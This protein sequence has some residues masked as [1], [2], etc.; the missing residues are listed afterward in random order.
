ML[1]VY[2]CHLRPGGGIFEEFETERFGFYLDLFIDVYFKET[3]FEMKLS[4][5]IYFFQQTQASFPSIGDREGRKKK[6]RNAVMT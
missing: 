5:Y 6:R 1:S 2:E 4:G 3:H